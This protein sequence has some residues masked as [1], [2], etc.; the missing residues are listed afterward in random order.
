MQQPD[1]PST[2]FFMARHPGSPILVQLRTATTHAEQI[3]ALKALKNDIVGHVQRKESWI[4]HGVLEPVVRVLIPPTSAAKLNGKDARFQLASRPL[5]DDDAVK[6]QALQLVTSF[7]NGMHF[8]VPTRA[9]DLA[10]SV[11]QVVLPFYRPCTPLEPS[12]PS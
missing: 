12:Q 6:L 5:S 2:S 3:A 10:D 4:G 1:V 9:A 8:P 11:L 7:A